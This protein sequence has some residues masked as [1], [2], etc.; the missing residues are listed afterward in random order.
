MDID[1]ALK[2]AGSAPDE[3]IFRKKY[4]VVSDAA[5]L[6]S[7]EILAAWNASLSQ[8]LRELERDLR[9]AVSP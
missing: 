9:A 2:R 3:E 4:S 6:S 1:F 5:G 8:I 7:K